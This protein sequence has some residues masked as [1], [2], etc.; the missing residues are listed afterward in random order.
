MADETPTPSAQADP[1]D[2][3]RRR[4][5]DAIAAAEEA[6]RRY[7]EL[8]ARAAQPP[9]PAPTPAPA[10]IPPELMSELE[11]L[12]TSRKRESEDR[13]IAYAKSQ[14]LKPELAE[15]PRDELVK[16]LPIVDPSSEEG[17][18]AFEAWRNA[19]SRSFSPKGPTVEQTRA[20]YEPRIDALRNKK[21]RLINPDAAFSG[22]KVRQ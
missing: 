1:S 18:A 11:L 4:Y 7:D 13:A 21:T 5:D 3:A 15:L 14:G 2:E 20:A 10:V 16:I 8:S 17:R 22:R 9:A 6:K 19:R 12:K